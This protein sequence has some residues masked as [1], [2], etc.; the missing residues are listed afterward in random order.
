MGRGQRSESRGAVKYRDQDLVEAQLGPAEAVVVDSTGAVVGGAWFNPRFQRLR[1]AT[2]RAI[3]SIEH[4]WRLQPF[5]RETLDRLEGLIAKE[6]GDPVAIVS[7]ERVEGQVAIRVEAL[8]GG[9]PTE[10]MR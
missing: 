2:E 1:D 3:A 4:P 8:I 5:A 6:L 7:V 10:I 9:I